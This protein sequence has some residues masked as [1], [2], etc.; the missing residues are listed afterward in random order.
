MEFYR[1]FEL[2]DFVY[3]FEDPNFKFEHDM[4]MYEFTYKT[5]DSRVIFWWE[6]AANMFRIE[7]STPQ[8]NMIY[9]RNDVTRILLFDKDNGIIEVDLENG[10]SVNIHLKPKITFN[11]DDDN[12][13]Q[14][15]IVC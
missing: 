14:F 8:V 3:A 11:L 5:D 10:D 2:E 7:I 12:M 4:G 13:T 9:S 1:N 6:E 15:S